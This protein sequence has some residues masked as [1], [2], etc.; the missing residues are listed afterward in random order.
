MEGGW[1]W[2][3][4]NWT[5]QLFEKHVMLINKCSEVAERVWWV[6]AWARPILA[7]AGWISPTLHTLSQ[8]W[9]KVPLGHGKP[10]SGRKSW[11]CKAFERRLR[12]I[13][14]SFVKIQHECWIWCS[15]SEQRKGVTRLR[16]QPSKKV[17][18]GRVGLQ[19]IHV[20]QLFA[21]SSASSGSQQAKVE[22]T[23]VQYRGIEL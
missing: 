23:S 22:V 5:M 16:C 8:T 2:Q 20:K 4:S 15:K 6:G 21:N 14:G 10:E 17:Y 12:C 7:Q 11:I 9:A 1:E 3:S 19:S 13:K 18:G